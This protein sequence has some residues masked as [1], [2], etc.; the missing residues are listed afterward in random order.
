V[1]DRI[2]DCLMQKEYKANQNKYMV[3]TNGYDPVDMAGI[4]KKQKNLFSIIYT[5][6]LNQYRTPVHFFKGLR[7]AFNMHPEMKNDLR[8]TFVG[9]NGNEYQHIIHQFGLESNVFFKGHLSHNKAVDALFESDL[10]LLISYSGNYSKENAEVHLTGKVFEYLMTG[11]PVLAL[12]EEGILTNL[13][14]KTRSGFSVPSNNITKIQ[15]IVIHLYFQW[16]GKK[17]D[18]NPDW[19]LIKTFDRKKITEKLSGILEDVSG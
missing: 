12:A 7:D 10:L 5:G 14:K 19:K 9:E 2:M 4:R 6:S 17:L 13:L 16:K 11:I 18:I 3:L 15:K 1:N 8:V